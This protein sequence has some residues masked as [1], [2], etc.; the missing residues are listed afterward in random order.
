MRNALFLSIYVALTIFGAS[1]LNASYEIHC[2]PAEALLERSSIKGPWKTTF[3]QT[4][5]PT[6]TAIELSQEDVGP[7]RP[8]TL[9][10]AILT[11]TAP[12][13][14]ILDCVYQGT[15]TFNA[16]KSSL[17][18]KPI[19]Q[20]FSLS[21]AIYSGNCTMPEEPMAKYIICP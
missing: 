8:W 9:I 18:P 21:G 4:L 13:T 11:N 15:F 3:A 14:Q 19:K 16:N 17:R 7:K 2:P 6:G 5:G 1:L 20:K 12:F 10:R